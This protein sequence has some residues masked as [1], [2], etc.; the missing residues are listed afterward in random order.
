MIQP[1]N[2]ILLLMSALLTTSVWYACGKKQPQAADVNPNGSSPLAMMMRDMLE[3]GQKM[4]SE[5]ME[6]KAPSTMPAAYHDMTKTQPTE[7]MIDNPAVFEG[8]SKHFLA[9]WDSLYTPGINTT[10]AF[11]SVVNSCINCHKSYC[12]GPIPAISKLKI[13]EN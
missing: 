5:I 4:R 6:G 11:N 12:Q 10:T 9:T 1:R 13:P 8:F 7:G 2:Y 3:T